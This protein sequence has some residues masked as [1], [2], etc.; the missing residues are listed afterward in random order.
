VL[1]Q[2]IVKLFETEDAINI[3][4]IKSVLEY[5]ETVTDKAEDVANTIENI[6]IKYA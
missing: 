5:L 6:V 4:K 3:I 2:A 1:S